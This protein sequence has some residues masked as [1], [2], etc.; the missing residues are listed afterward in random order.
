MK[1]IY[2]LLLLN[3]GFGFAQEVNK[4]IVNVTSIPVGYYNTATGTGYTLKT[5]LHNIINNNTNSSGIDNYGDLWTFYTNP[6]MRD[7]YYENNGTLLDIYSEKPTGLDSYEYSG[8]GQQCGGTTP[9]VEGN[10]YNREHII[11]QSVFS[12]NYPMYSDAHFVLPSDN[13]VNGWRNNYSF[14]K[15]VSTTGVP[16]TNSAASGAGSTPCYSTNNSRL[17]QNVNSGYS[18]GYSG[19][20]FEP[21]DEFKGDVARAILYFVTCY[22]DRIPSYTFDMFNGTVNQSLTDTFL[23]IM[24]TWHQ[25]D[26]VSAYEIAKNDAVYSH[27]NNRNPY[28]DHPEY[29]CLIWSATCAALNTD[30]FEL[31]ADINVYP[32][33]SNDQKINIETQNELDEIQLIN[34]NGQIMKQISNPVRNQN[35]Y[36]L[37]NLPKG[38]Y[39]LKLSADNA[40][41][42]KKIIIN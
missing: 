18:S 34:V 5:N 26:P 28:I 15:V 21:I 22:Q 23:N 41:E 31:I 6:A 16:C 25:L 1:K 17:G 39:F 35:K 12:S 8:T 27:Q 14:G 40:T 37:E 36:I 20:V 7:N 13:R 11:P 29:A 4:N 2:L 30:S 32:N 24:L 19:I 33:P 3:V 42:T 10:C 9:S 38:F